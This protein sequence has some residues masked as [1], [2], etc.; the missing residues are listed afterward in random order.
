MSNK[1]G[2]I[3]FGNMG[4]AIINGA[5]KKNLLKKEDIY[6][7]DPSEKAMEAAKKAGFNQALSNRELVEECDIILL[8]VKPQYHKETLEET[9]K[10]LEGKCMISIVAGITV[11]RLNQAIDA[12]PRILRVMPNTPALVFEGAFALCRDNNLSE[13]E[14][15]FAENLFSSIGIVEWVKEYDIDAVCGLSGGGPA[16]AAMFIEALADGGVKEGL[17]RDVAYRLAAQTVMGTAK[18]IL[19]LDMHPGQLKDMVTSP[20]GTTIE[21]VE[22][23]EKNGF[24]YAA[25]RAVIAGTEKSRKL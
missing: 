6:V 5:V 11:E 9:G 24:R 3:G 1:F 16:Y 25:M 23:L 8:A 22:E 12:S 10:A 4:G 13:E 7:Y 14:E 15:S 20:S 18:M 21:A 17:K 2:V 19:D